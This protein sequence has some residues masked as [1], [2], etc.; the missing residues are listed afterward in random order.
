M[1]IVE[2]IEAF[3]HGYSTA[4]SFTHPSQFSKIG[5]IWVCQDAPRKASAYRGSEYIVYGV[6][7]EEAVDRIRRHSD[8][9]Y[10]ISV[11]SAPRDHPRAIRDEY[12]RLGYRLLRSEP[13]MVCP[14]RQAKRYEC[15]TPIRRVETTEEALA[16]AQCGSGRRLILSEHIGVD[17][18]PIRLYSAQCDGVS[19]AWARSIRHGPNAYVAGCYVKP[20]HRG[21]GIGRSL[22]SKLLEDDERLGVRTSVLLASSAGAR[23]YPW[24]GYEQIGLL[25]LFTP[26]HAPKP[27]T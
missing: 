7:P 4:R 27:K 20:E 2:A 22:M 6:E 10:A 9:R 23:L 8:R 24:L 17:D 3:G 13:F 25:Q 19:L 15:Q 21:K 1:D 5:P 16:A 11:V 12:R 14:L 26:I 18:A